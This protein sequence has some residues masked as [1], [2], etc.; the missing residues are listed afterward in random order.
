LAVVV[1]WLLSRVVRQGTARLRPLE[2][3]LR[4]LQSQLQTQRAQTATVVENL[5]SGVIVIDSRGQVVLA[6]SAAK[7]LFAIH[8]QPT[9]HQLVE[10][11]RQPELLQAVRQLFADRAPREAIVEVRDTEGVR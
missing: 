9:G 4:V 7:R 8:R 10:S 2:K 11:V 6:N 3:E 5:G 1:A